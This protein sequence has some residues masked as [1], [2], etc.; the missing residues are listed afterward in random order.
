LIVPGV[1]G[2]SFTTRS[3]STPPVPSARPVGGPA[4]ADDVRGGV[5]IFGI[6][7]LQ[8]T[9]LLRLENRLSL[10]GSSRFFWHILRCRSS[11]SPNGYAGD[12]ANRLTIN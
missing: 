7:A 6:N 11:F 12:I 5:A 9:Y 10:H 1:V 2:S 4:Y 8:Q 3:S